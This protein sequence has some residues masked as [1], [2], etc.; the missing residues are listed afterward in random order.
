[1]VTTL[2]L[3]LACMGILGIAFGAGLAA[4][5]KRFK[6]EMD[7]RVEE[8]LDAL[9]NVNCGACG[10]AGC[11]AFAAAVVKGEAPV[12][13]C[14]PGG[15]ECARGVAA[16]MG[17]EVGEV[18]KRR[19]VVRCQGGEAEARREFDYDGVRECRAAVLLGGGPKACKFGCVGFGTCVAACPFEAIEMGADGLPVVSE[20]K[21]TACGLC[22]KAC[23]VGII[24]ILPS[25]HRVFLACSNP[26]RGKE[27]KAVCTR[28]CIAC[29]ACVKATES[30]A[31]TWGDGLPEIDYERWT[32]PEAALEKC[33]MDCFADRRAAGVPA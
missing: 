8:V 26:G 10:Y 21:C 13:G 12:V 19:A 27:V 14:V 32:D 15:L 11:A 25:R 33:P 23:P 16:I 31:I 2:L 24:T 22:A 4:A 5:A 29:R 6:I 1:M 3:S 18:E 30:G 28:G 9:P 17:A 20:E 7:P